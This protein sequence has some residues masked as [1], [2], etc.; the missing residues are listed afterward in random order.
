MFTSCVIWGTDLATEQVLIYV[1][2]LSDKVIVDMKG[3]MSFYDRENLCLMSYRKLQGVYHG[4]TQENFP[5]IFES[6]ADFTLGMSLFAICAHRY[7]DLQFLT[8]ELMTNH[9]HIVVA[10]SSDEI[11]DFFNEFKKVLE[12]KLNKNLDELNLTLHPV[13]DLENLRNV[14]AYANRNGSVVNEDVCPYTYPWGANRFYF[15]EEAKL[16]SV[17]KVCV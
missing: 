14:I 7:P 12:R 4:C 16:G 8:F 15:N 3:G 1:H 9:V 11:L 13:T 10:G 6:K 2:R 17:A 5:L